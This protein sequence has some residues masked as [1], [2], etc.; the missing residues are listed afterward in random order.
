MNAPMR[1]PMSLEVFLEWEDRQPTR[2][3]FDGVHAVA[4]TGGTAAHAQIQASV[5]FAM[6]G[7]LRGKPCRFVR[8]DLKVQVNG[9]VRY[10]D[11]FVSCTAY[12]PDAK[13]ISD[14]VV[15]FEILSPG[16]ASV[17][18]IAKNADYAATPSVMHYVILSQNSISASVFAREGGD[19][20][21][22]VLDAKAVLHMPEIGVEVPL[23]AFYESVT[24]APEEPGTA[25]TA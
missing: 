12:P 6:F 8:P 10:P 13:F 1:K 18:L 4:M 19:W 22:R 21:G 17:D 15:I 23:A 25:V 14:P 5:A 11:G 2:H 24:L 20:V 16:T 7:R 3:E 9:R